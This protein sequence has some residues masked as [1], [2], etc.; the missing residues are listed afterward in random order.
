MRHLLDQQTGI[1]V[2]G[3]AG[4]GRVAIDLVR[5]LSPDAVV[6]DV[7]MPSMNGIDADAPDP[8]GQ[9]LR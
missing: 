7:V 3:E 1:E 2:V 9:A 4:D 8:E 6:I 5:Q